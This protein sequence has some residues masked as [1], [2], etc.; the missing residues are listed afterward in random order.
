MTTDAVPLLRVGQVVVTLAGEILGSDTEESREL[1]RR[2]KACINACDGISTAELEQGIIAD[3]C[4]VLGQ[5]VPLLEAQSRQ[6]NAGEKA[7]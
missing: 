4:R 1:A 7:A 6:R 3:M 2:V 5:V